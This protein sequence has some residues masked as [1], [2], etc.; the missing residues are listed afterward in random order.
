MGTPCAEHVVKTMHQTS[1][2][3]AVTYARDGS[4]ESVLRSLQLGLSTSSS[5][6]ARLAATREPVLNEHR[7]PSRVR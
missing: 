2:G 6:N 5:T 1:S 4:M 7:S 3:F